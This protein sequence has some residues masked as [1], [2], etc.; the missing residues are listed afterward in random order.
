MT[1]KYGGSAGTG[2]MPTGE[3]DYQD[4]TANFDSK[5]TDANTWLESKSQD[6]NVL[7]RTIGSGFD[8][9]KRVFFRW[10]SGDSK[11]TDRLV[12]KAG[13]KLNLHDNRIWR[14]FGA[15]NWLTNLFQRDA[16]KLTEN[17]ELDTEG[18]FLSK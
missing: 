15:F 4:I 6:Q 14:H 18:F 9:I 8:T 11:D 2:D 10:Y 13:D 16:D 3:A 17:S 7:M 5:A 1:K 12:S